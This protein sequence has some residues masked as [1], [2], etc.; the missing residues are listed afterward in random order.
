MAKGSIEKR[1]DNSWRLVIDVGYDYDGKRIKRTK[2]IRIEDKALLK[3]TKKLKDYLDAEL[4]KFRIEVESGEYITPE[5]MTF[6]SFAENEWLKKFAEGRYSPKNLKNTTTIL[7]S[8]ILP[9]FGH[10]QINDIKPLHV[11]TF[12][13]NLHDQKARKDGKEKPLTGSTI[14]NIYKVLKSILS[15]AYEWRVIQKN[16]I[17]N[18]EKPKLERKKMKYYE[19]NE[20]EQV[21]QALYHE[22]IIWRLY[23]LG[24]M[25][26]GFRRGE[27]L[28]IEWPEVNF[29]DNTFTI[30]KSYSV[31]KDGQPIIT[32][33]KTDASIRAVVMPVWYMRELKEYQLWWKKER[34]KLGDKWQGGENQY[35]FH[36]GFGK[37]YYPDTATAT[38]RKFLKRH[39]FRHIRLH[40][41]RHTAAT[42]LIEAGIKAGVN[43]D[44]T[45]KAV[46][47]RLG[48]TKYQTTADI[49]A[50]ITKRVSKDVASALEKYDPKNPS[51]N[52]PQDII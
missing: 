6:A 1:G 50:H 29:E 26:G 40:D 9:A 37:P 52:R 12:L 18:I 32:K 21:I 8:H 33:P 51:P 25:L 19:E 42:L 39:G 22:P 11:V 45:L 34:L 20:A 3:T 49:Y 43:E 27:L 47:E 46:Q 10:I 36:N 13:N 16:P 14:N 5:K 30:L 44:L 17:E 23:F 31:F 28:A 41:L 35:V 4:A 38:W 24:S 48:H 15:K 2:T 7:R